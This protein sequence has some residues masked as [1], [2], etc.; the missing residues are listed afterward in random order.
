L[1]GA[2]REEKIEEIL[3]KLQVPEDVELRY[4]EFDDILHQVEPQRGR[5][6]EQALAKVFRPLAH[7]IVGEQKKSQGPEVPPRAG[8]NIVHVT[9]PVERPNPCQQI[10]ARK[11]RAHVLL[12]GLK[13]CN[14]IFADHLMP[15]TRN[16]AAPRGGVALGVLGVGMV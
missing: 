13:I 16:H 6:F 14:S 15:S 3:A 8:D 1:R 5:K 12:P 4:D 10:T 2:E 9:V 11:C 7:D